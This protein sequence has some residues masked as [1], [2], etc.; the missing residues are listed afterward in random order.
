MII[1]VWGSRLM[2]DDSKILVFIAG[3][4]DE[5]QLRNLIQNARKQNN[6]IVER[7]AFLRLIALVPAANPGT[8]EHDFWQTVHAFEEMLSE[9][10]GRT[11]RLSRTRQKV[12]RVGVIQTLKDWALSEKE[13]DGFT[14]LLERQ[15]PE[16]TGEAIVLRHPQHFDDAVQN[17]AKN[18]LMAAKVDIH[19]LPKARAN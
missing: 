14:K 5:A 11:T 9:E 15:M 6:R 1:Q 12:Q 8:V 18:R 7:A 4:S 3:C 13:T 17:A 2:G 19:K 16:M 10:R